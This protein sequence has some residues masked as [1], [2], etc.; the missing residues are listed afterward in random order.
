MA[1][2]LKDCVNRGGEGIGLGL[3][4][5]AAALSDLIGAVGQT[6]EELAYL[7]ADLGAGA[8]AGLSRHFGPDPAPDRLI[9]SNLLHLR[10][11]ARANQA[12]LAWLR[13]GRRLGRPLRQGG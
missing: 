5:G 11:F 8:E 13:L 12:R 4:D 9:G 7:L 2:G 6:P 3:Q 1:G 10:W